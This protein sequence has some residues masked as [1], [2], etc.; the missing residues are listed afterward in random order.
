MAGIKA[1]EQLYHLQNLKKNTI[2]EKITKLKENYE[3]NSTEIRKL[4]RELGKIQDSELGDKLQDLKIFEI[5][6][7][8]KSS[9]HFLDLTKKT[10]SCEKLSDICDNAGNV[11][12]SAES[13]NKYITNFYSSLYRC[14]SKVQGE[15]E[16][17]LGHG[18]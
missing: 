10:S 14:D 7:A 9:P 12:L 11:L 8:E 18:P 4:E 2:T 16:D 5:L 13:L 1:Q 15:I 6:N 3:D 17:F